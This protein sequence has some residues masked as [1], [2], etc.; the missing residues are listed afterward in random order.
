MW[1]SSFIVTLG[2]SVELMAYLLPLF[3]GI[4][5]IALRDDINRV[6]NP[7]TLFCATKIAPLK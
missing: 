2:A 7:R 4:W 5:R 3:V 1:F 6:F